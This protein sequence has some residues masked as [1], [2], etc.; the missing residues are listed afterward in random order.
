MQ[1]KVVGVQF[2]EGGKIYHF[3]PN[4]LDLKINDYVIVR[5]ESG[6]EFAMIASKIKE[7][8]EASLTV[9]LKEVIRVATKSDIKKQEQNKEKAFEAFEKAEKIVEQ[10]KLDMKLIEAEYTFDASKIIF[11]F[12]ADNRVDFRELVKD[13]AKKLKARIELRQVGP[14]DEA[15]VIGGLGP[16]GRE[17]CCGS[18][19]KDFTKVSMKMAKNQNLSLNPSKINGVCGKLMCCLSYENDYYKEVSKEMPK[20]N[21]KVKTPDGEGKV[22]YNNLLKKIV[23]VKLFEDGDSYN[24][25]EYPAKDVKEIKS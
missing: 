14:R 19:M 10:H 9:P 4:N 11:T 18:Y 22:M 23:T 7:V 2:K 1:I 13:L 21:K 16:C 24:F 6:K 12:V 25:R 3:S 17:V 20:I 15:K 8:K 5:T